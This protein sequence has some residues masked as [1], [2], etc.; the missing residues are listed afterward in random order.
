MSQQDNYSDIIFKAAAKLAAMGLPIVQ[1]YGMENGRC[2][3][4][5][6]HACGMPGK[7][8][9]NADWMP[10][11]T[12]DEEA[13]ASWFED[14]R[15]WNIGVPM[16]P[17]SNL[18][19]TEWDDEESKRTAKKYGIIDAVTPGFSSNRGGHRLWI[20]DPRL[21][22]IS[23][24][25]K[26]IG[27]LEVRFG[28]G[29]KQTQSIF[30]PSQHHTGK[31]YT[32]DAGRSPEE[33]EFAKMPEA[34]V[35]AV[36]AACRGEGK[37]KTITKDTVMQRV[38]Q[39]GE[40][41]DGLLAYVSSQIM[42]MRDP[43]DPE[44]Q[45]H[46]LLVLRSLNKTQ[47]HKPLDDKEIEAIWQSQLR[48]G[49]K[50]RA[51]GVVG[52]ASTDEDAD[53]KVLDA[54]AQSVHTA[55]GLEY[56]DGEWWPGKWTLTV[57]H[58]EPKEFRLRVPFI[59][60]C[61]D[62][63]DFA[64]IS[65]NSADWSTPAAV[66]RKILEATGTIDVADPCP[67]EW[68]KIWNGYS[69]KAEGSRERVHVRGLKVKLM[70]ERSEETPPPDQK[71]SVVLAGYLLDAL[72]ST[73]PPDEQSD[74]SRP[75]PSGKPAWVRNE[76]EG[77]DLYWQWSRVFEEIKKK[78][79]YRAEDGE[80]IGLKRLILSKTGERDFRVKRV[81]VEDGSKKRFYVWSKRHLE[82]LNDLAHPDTDPSDE[83]TTTS[84]G[85]SKKRNLSEAAGTLESCPT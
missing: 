75:N 30:P 80:Q 69:R 7:H 70:D 85:P 2:M 17:A 14:G 48:W 51:A 66:A 26:K 40:R 62:G 10:H 27:G 15:P 28:G 61:G 11:S 49:F 45:Q 41:H 18:V 9:V 29:G 36:L 19:D 38:L 8:P 16:G 46:V 21:A 12:T 74:E 3:C 22:G 13:I 20:L 50:A 83:S 1:N 67:A 82:V 6:R 78:R 59:G 58:G 33:V 79:D 5:R 56:R 73:A 68:V 65:L 4:H 31:V 32:W 34:L 64:S 24:G 55:S 44:E 81:V 39:E 35:S 72:N 60:A 84:N 37:E 54:R 52:V 57:V 77:F 23:K 76:N 53:E 63:D 47:C 71:R 25:V 43:H 42:R